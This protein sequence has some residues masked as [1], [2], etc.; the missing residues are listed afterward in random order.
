MLM[1]QGFRVT[2]TIT[3]SATGQPMPGVTVLVKGTNQGTATDIDGNYSIE[4]PDQN[5]VL[6]FS[7]V[8]YAEREIPVNG[9]TVINV[10]MEESTEMLDELIVVAYGT[11]KRESFTGSAAV[12]KGDAIKKIP[13]IFE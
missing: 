10:T 1:A 12:V 3:E 11:T 6:V 9:Q 13:V 8:G 5:A 7:S 4:V 2:G